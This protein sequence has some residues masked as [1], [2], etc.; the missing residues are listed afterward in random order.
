L[1]SAAHHCDGLARY[2]ELP[3]SKDIRSIPASKT[4]YPPPGPQDAEK[5]GPGIE[6]PILHVAVYDG[7]ES[8]NEI[9]ES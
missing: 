6:H 4:G 9:I 3:K 5:A 2:H 1:G 7:V 8:V